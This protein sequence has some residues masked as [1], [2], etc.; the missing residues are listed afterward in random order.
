VLF[1][2]RV[3]SRQKHDSTAVQSAA[4]EGGS[5][6][7]AAV[8]HAPP[9]T[10]KMPAYVQ[11]DGTIVHGAAPPQDLWRKRFLCGMGFLL[12]YNFIMSDTFDGT[13]S[14]SPRLGGKDDL[15][16]SKVPAAERSDHWSY[17]F[18]QRQ[19]F[20]RHYTRH[21]DKDKVAWLRTPSLDDFIQ[22]GGD[23]MTDSG[24]RNGHDPED[25]NIHGTVNDIT[26]SVAVTRCSSTNYAIT[27]CVCL[28][29]CM[30]A[31]MYVPNV[32][33][34]VCKHVCMYVCVRVCVSLCMYV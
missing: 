32:R 5:H 11:A 33:G 21:A 14:L 8:P 15:A 16:D 3:V 34:H 13:G 4:R 17:I 24:G 30:Y 10:D 12:L 1:S 7:A 2:K 9:P 28:Y 27:A 6:V 31:S 26:E 22:T 20:V 29:I 23:R 19:T 25:I 18:A